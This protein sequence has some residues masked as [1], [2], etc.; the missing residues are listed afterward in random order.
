MAL[1]FEANLSSG[2]LN[3]PKKERLAHGFKDGD[4]F[5]VVIQKVKS[6]PVKEA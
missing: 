4:R 2:R 6:V 1:E 3:V 5:K